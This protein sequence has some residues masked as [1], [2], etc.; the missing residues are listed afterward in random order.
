MIEIFIIAGHFDRPSVKALTVSLIGPIVI[1]IDMVSAKDLPNVCVSIYQT[2]KPRVTQTLCRFCEP[3]LRSLM[4]TATQARAPLTVHLMPSQGVGI[5]NLTPRVMNPV[6]NTA[7]KPT[8]PIRNM[9]VKSPETSGL[10]TSNIQVT[11]PELGDAHTLVLPHQHSGTDITNTRLL[12]QI[13]AKAESVLKTIIEYLETSDMQIE[14]S[15]DTDTGLGVAPILVLSHQP[16]GTEITCAG[17]LPPLAAKA[18]PVREKETENMEMSR[19]QTR[20]TRGTDQ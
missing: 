7:T 9:K 2:N 12:P 11:D 8:P 13:V 6:L 19:M 16:I 17:P 5:Q 3:R 20:D 18:K 4:K 15:Q 10:Q 1:Q 14:N